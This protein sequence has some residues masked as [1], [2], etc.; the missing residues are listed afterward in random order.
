MTFRPADGTPAERLWRE[1]SLH[2]AQACG[3]AGAGGEVVVRRDHPAL[4]LVDDEHLLDAIVFG[5]GAS[6][7][8]RVI[9]A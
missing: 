7:V 2:G 3:F 1:G 6:V 5:A 9:P 8:E 4:E